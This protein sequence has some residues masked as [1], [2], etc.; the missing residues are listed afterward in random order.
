V[1]YFLEL[2]MKEAV[3]E[4]LDLSLEMNV[5]SVRGLEIM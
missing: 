4:E 5:V 1:D 2:W 3:K